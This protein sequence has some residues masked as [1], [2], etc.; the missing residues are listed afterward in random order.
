MT[1]F[2]EFMSCRAATSLTIPLDLFL[3][4]F[5]TSSLSFSISVSRLLLLF[6]LF[7]FLCIIS[8][9][10]ISASHSTALG[11]SGSRLPPVPS[12]ALFG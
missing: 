1:A 10:I 5:L 4:P 9:E 6:H 11:R 3:S 12:T 8:H 7:S 2:T